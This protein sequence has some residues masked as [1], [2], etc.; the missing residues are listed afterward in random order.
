[1]KNLE[2]IME[3]EMMTVKE[4]REKLDRTEKDKIRQSLQNCRYVLEH[5][6]LLKGA[7]QRN[8]LTCQIDITKEVP[9]KRR[10]VH[11]TDTDMNNLT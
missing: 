8:D 2:E 6:P 1:M 10:D 4:I 7:I 11:M 9:W 3:D 5:D